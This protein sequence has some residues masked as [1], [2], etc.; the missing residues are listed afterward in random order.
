ML[1]S[2]SSSKAHNHFLC[3]YYFSSQQQLP[4]LLTQSRKIKM[5]ITIIFQKMMVSSCK[6]VDHL[7]VLC[8]PAAFRALFHLM[9]MFWPRLWH[10]VMAIAPTFPYWNDTNK[11]WLLLR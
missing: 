6:N 9:P 3:I 4:G 7:A 5:M 2:L 10:S 1:A 11:Y 8:L